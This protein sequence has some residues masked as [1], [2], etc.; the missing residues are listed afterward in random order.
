MKRLFLLC[1][2]L[3][4]IFSL[5]ACSCEID[6]SKFDLT[7]YNFGLTDSKIDQISSS[8]NA[9]DESA[10]HEDDP[11]FSEASLNYI[12]PE[13]S[14]IIYNPWAVVSPEDFRDM[15]EDKL[16]EIADLTADMN[17]LKKE[18]L[19][20]TSVYR[21]SSNEKFSKTLN[22]IRAWSYGARNYPSDGL[23]DEDL[24]ILDLFII[25]G[26]DSSEYGARFPS[27]LITGNHDMIGT[28]ENLIISQIV[29]LD[30]L[31]SN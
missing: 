10:Q 26:T 7:K 24:A 18:L 1:L 20:Y 2:I 25:L 29:N 3:I 16:M 5:S 31:I 12:V 8:D 27:L 30:T 4:L 15:A 6:W 19:D 9:S 28:Y 21:L 13:K 17:A 22:N 14:G 23:S 11:V